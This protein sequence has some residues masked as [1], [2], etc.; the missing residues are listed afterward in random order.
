MKKYTYTSVIGLLDQM[1]REEMEK[2]YNPIEHHQDLI[3]NYGEKFAD[4]VTLEFKGKR[5]MFA[6]L[7]ALINRMKDEDAIELEAIRH[8]YPLIEYDQD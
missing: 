5:A 7:L 4:D 2:E 6:Q 1:F 3:K 8:I